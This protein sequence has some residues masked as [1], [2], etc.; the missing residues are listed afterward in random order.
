MQLENALLLQRALTLIHPA[1]AEDTVGP[2]NVAADVARSHCS[3]HLSSICTR[4]LTASVQCSECGWCLQAEVEADNRHMDVKD[5]L[6][7]FFGLPVKALDI[8]GLVGR[9]RILSRKVTS[10]TEC[11]PAAAG[12]W[13]GSADL[14]GPCRCTAS[15]LS[16]C[17]YDVL[18]TAHHMQKPHYVH[19]LQIAAAPDPPKHFRIDV[20]GVP[21]SKWGKACG[22][23]AKDD[24]MLLL[25]VHW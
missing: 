4:S 12:W 13:V 24:A 17:A 18:V 20:S 21:A 16:S 19:C 2:L 23:T 11:L 6:L 10:P 1:G 7:E 5:A 22:W 15:C 3:L 9:M 14:A 8:P 25:G